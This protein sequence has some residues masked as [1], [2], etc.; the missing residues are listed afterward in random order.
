MT[1]PKSITIIGRR[2][3][4]RTN[5][6]TYHTAEVIIDGEHAHTTGITYGYGNQYRQTALQWVKENVT[7]DLDGITTHATHT[8]VKR[9]KDL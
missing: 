6:N 3:F 5:G 7:Q 1:K 4:E 8:D 2:W 9:K